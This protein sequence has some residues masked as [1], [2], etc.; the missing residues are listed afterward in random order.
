M[1]A[2]A[3]A[4]GLSPL[5]LAFLS[6]C[7][8]KLSLIDRQAERQSELAFAEAEAVRAS[9]AEAEAEAAASEPLTDERRDSDPSSRLRRRPR[10][11]SGTS[12]SR[13]RTPARSAG[14]GGRASRQA[15]QSGLSSLSLSLVND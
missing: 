2:V 10:A 4:V 1:A 8:G 14:A 13:R 9:A 3:A 12:S 7:E 5:E 11:A 6:T 15:D